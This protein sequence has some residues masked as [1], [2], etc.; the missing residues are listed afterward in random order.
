MLFPRWHISCDGCGRAGCGAPRAF[1]S[2]N[3]LEDFDTVVQAEASWHCHCTLSMDFMLS[4]PVGRAEFD[5]ASVK[6][7]CQQSSPAF[8]A[9]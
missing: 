3:S 5:P 2:G 6:K 9:V 7:V 8:A 1:W 4:V